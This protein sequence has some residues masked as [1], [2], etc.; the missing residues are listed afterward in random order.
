[1]KQLLVTASVILVITSAAFGQGGLTYVNQMYDFGHIP[2]DYTVFHD[3]QIYNE[4][5]KALKIDSARAN[6]DCSRAIVLDS[7]VR[8]GDTVGVR[9]SFETTN[10]FGP[11]NKVMNVY[12]SDPNLPEI[13]FFY[14]SIV[15]QW[16]DGLKPD[17]INLFFL[18]PHK[19]KTVS[20]PNKQFNNI[21]LYYEDQLD[22]LFDVR[23]LKDIAR[24]N[25]RA[26]AEI[27]PRPGLGAGTYV[28]N[29]RFRIE[30]TD[31][32]PVYITVPVK[33]VRY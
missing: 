17:P 31:H 18:P 5:S 13:E 29:V 10:F 3:F 32:D 12:T 4:G 22:T 27:V 1:M 21:K 11:N 7:I 8:P 19:Q 30:P 15:G 2:L 28:S 26:E 9:I 33:I 20:F 24:R 6:C 14:L 25:E 16:F 23:I